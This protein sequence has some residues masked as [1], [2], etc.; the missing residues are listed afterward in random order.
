VEAH[1][2]SRT[3]VLVCQGRAAAHE[4][5][6]PQR[7]TDPTAMT[8]LRADERV[9]VEQVRG[10]TPP[11]G[12]RDRLGFETVRASAEVVV[13]RTVAIDEAVRART[14]P[15]L[16]VLGAGLDGRVWRMAE[17][18]D[19]EAY[20]VDHPASQRDKRER[21]GERP[22]LARSVRYVPVD[23]E[24]DRLG[25]ALAAAGHQRSMAT[26]WL[27]EGVVPYLAK[28][29]VT[30]TVAVIAERSA[31]GSCL[32]VNY[33]APAVSAVLGRLVARA[34]SVAVRQPSPWRSEPR[35]SSWTPDAIRELLARQGLT[36]DGDDDLLTIAQ[37]LPMPVRQRRSLRNGRVA[38]ATVG[39]R[40]AT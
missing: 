35:R 25:D 36:V 16:V 21:V 17:L 3:A 6:A 23:F 34:M 39:P 10:G 27:W 31:S 22:P 12:A 28:A 38:T 13:P 9:P 5:I 20:E 14:A 32:I 1:R 19:V 11:R 24:R 4:R 33:Q 26:T 29:D 7:F 40:P 18:A 30:S 8:M 2:F 15:Q 37:R